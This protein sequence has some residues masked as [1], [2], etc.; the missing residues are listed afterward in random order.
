MSAAWYPTVDRVESAFEIAVDDPGYGYLY[1]RAL[2]DDLGLG[3]WSTTLAG[4]Q[5][6]AWLTVLTARALCTTGEYDSRFRIEER[7]EARGRDGVPS[8]VT[9]AIARDLLPAF[10]S[11]VLLAAAGTEKHERILVD[12]D[13]RPPEVICARCDVAS[14]YAEADATSAWCDEHGHRPFGYVYDLWD[15]ALGSREVKV[16]S[17]EF[18]RRMAASGLSGASFG[19]SV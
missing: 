15:G 11:A 13:D 18:R 14:P 9:S 6:G 2:G 3:D 10:Q 19:R 17:W 5:L 16:S 4:E 12:E 8:W 7:G 1:I